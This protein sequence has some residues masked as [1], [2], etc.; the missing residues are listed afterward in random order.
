M[1]FLTP[2]FLGGLLAALVPVLIHLIQRDRK[3]VVRFPSLMFLE[4]I[5]FRSVRRQTIRNWPLFLMRLAAVIL[6]VLAFARPFFSSSA[7]ELAAG[8]PLER[9]VLID[10]SY[11]LAW[12]GSFARA[13]DQARQALGSLQDGDRASV[14]AFDD[15]AAVLARSVDPTTALRALE[16][17]AP[18]TRTT[19]FRPALEITQAI[20]E[21][22][23]LGRR[24]VIL[25]SDFQRLAWRGDE[26]IELPGGTELTPVSVRP[27]RQRN[28]ALWTVA[29]ERS[30]TAERERV[31]ATARLVNLGSEPAHPTVTL[32]LGGRS[33][34]T[35]TVALAGAGSGEATANVTFQPFTLPGENTLAR[36]R[37]DEDDLAPDNTFD[38]VLDPE[39]APSVLVVEP[40]GARANASLYLTR[41]LEIGGEVP[42]R[43]DVV[44]A[45]RLTPAMIA[46]HAVIL[47]NG[48]GVEGDAAGNALR[49]HVENGGGLLVA[50]DERSR[51]P[52][53]YADLLPGRFGSAT[54]RSGAALGYLDYTHPVFELF[55]RPRSG[56]FTAARFFRYRTL[57][58]DSTADVLARFDDGGVA[59]AERRVGLGRSLVWTTGLDNFWND[60][61]L[62]PVYLPFVHALVQ[63]LSGRSNQTPSYT[64]G[65]VVDL[66]AEDS[67]ENEGEWLVLTP[68]GRPLTVNAD[69]T[70]A[71]FLMLDEAG[72]YEVRHRQDGPAV[73][74][75]AANVDRSESALTTVDPEVVVAAVGSTQPAGVPA[76]T[77]RD[78]VEVRRAQEA[79]SGVGWY[80]LLAVFGLLALETTVSNRASRRPA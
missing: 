54:D 61:A 50:L 23:R 73:R 72:V 78:P 28:V 62:Q 4:R 76:E 67:G 16:G 57:T 12:E 39:A 34:E 65:E 42:F 75:I 25:I 37:I 2:L 48:A 68:S 46:Q 11:S 20:L 49:Q 79:R 56:D 9:V 24:D 52:D 15:G 8:G 69:E 53:A 6:L 70:G 18:G 29:L 36:V 40:G 74:R 14:V 60:L 63:H 38:L 17:L 41:A 26:D 5:P 22:S 10:R 32:E 64:V 31:E 66:A 27:E 21:Q 59:L 51:W 7:A 1:S 80:L 44:R 33:L 3:T 19:R 58:P 55:S 71:R 77:E 30:R 43:V 35:R 13:L 47:F 45:N